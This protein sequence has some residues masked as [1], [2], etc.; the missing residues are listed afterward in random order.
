V[1]RHSGK[2]RVGTRQ[3]HAL[4]AEVAQ[5]LSS[6]PAWSIEQSSQDCYTKKPSLQKQNKQAN[7]QN[8]NPTRWDTLGRGVGATGLNAPE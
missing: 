4:Q 5:S 2:S 7:K 6:R 3:S 8:K 1:I